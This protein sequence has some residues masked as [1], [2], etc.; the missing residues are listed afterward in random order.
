MVNNNDSFSLSIEKRIYYDDFN[1]TIT[2]KFS[3]KEMAQLKSLIQ[4]KLENISS[5]RYQLISYVE[6]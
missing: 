4:Q 5:K 1:Q 2:V 6:I 3:R